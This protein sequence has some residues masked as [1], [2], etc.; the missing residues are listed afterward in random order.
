[1]TKRKLTQAA[2]KDVLEAAGFQVVFRQSL[3]TN[4]DF[5]IYP[6]DGSMTAR[7]SVDR[8]THEIDTLEVFPRQSGRGTDPYYVLSSLTQL[9]KI[10]K[11]AKVSH[12]NLVPAFERRKAEE[13]VNV[14]NAAAFLMQVAEALAK[15]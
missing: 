5:N 7:L 2:L 13:L 6:A 15:V 14:E 10:N 11:L 12:L 4:F 3:A 1:M 9:V 8:T